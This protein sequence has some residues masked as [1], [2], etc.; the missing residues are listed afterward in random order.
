MKRLLFIFV[1][2]FISV[3]AQ[4]STGTVS[5]SGSGT[6]V[7]VVYV[8]AGKYTVT[9]WH[10]GQ[11]NCIAVAHYL[12]GDIPGNVLMANFI[13]AKSETV[14]A[15]F[16]GTGKYAFEVKA[17]GR[18][19]IRMTRLDTPQNTSTEPILQPS[20]PMHAEPTIP[21]EVYHQKRQPPDKKITQ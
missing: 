5:C 1:M 6:I 11:S 15:E 10:E 2:F 7:Q 12:A 19:E 18:W 16:S 20:K 21:L 9:V 4:S 3:P 17:D 13:G 14:F 8:E